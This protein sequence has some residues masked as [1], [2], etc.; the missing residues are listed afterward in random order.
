MNG[1]T[2][3]VLRE[4]LAYPNGYL[5]VSDIAFKTNMT[6]KQIF[7]IIGILNLP[8]VHKEYDPDI[9]TPRFRI[10]ATL[11]ERETALRDAT[12]DY[13]EISEDMMD[14]VYRNLSSV[15]WLS[16]SD[17]AEDTGMNTQDVSKT[18]SVLTGVVTKERGSS[19]Y[20]RRAEQVL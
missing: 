4:I 8:F 6:S 15:G 1:K 19:V 2:Y 14:I 17:L 3:K 10:E 16:I 13:Y 11:E 5:S 9:K 7:S 18:L 12:I 20:Y